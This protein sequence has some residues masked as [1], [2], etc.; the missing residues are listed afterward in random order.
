MA[1]FAPAVAVL[2]RLEGGYAKYDN[3][4]GSVNFGI[5]A[6][7]LREHNYTETPETLTKERATEIYKYHFWGHYRLGEINDQRLATAALICIVN[8]EYWG[9]R[10]LQIAARAEPDG[11]IGP[12]TLAAVNAMDPIHALTGLQASMLRWYE[13]LA[14]N[15]PK[16]YADDLPGWRRRLEEL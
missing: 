4:A 5:T 14:A 11:V 6:R 12:K 1:D 15:N 2:L 10:A 16:Q 7:F 9:P 8:T 13:K 3:T